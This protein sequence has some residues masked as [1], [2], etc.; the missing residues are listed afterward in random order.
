MVKRLSVGLV[1]VFVMSMLWLP[2]AAG[3]APS[4]DYTVKDTE[5]SSAPYHGAS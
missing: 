3:A 1:V 2:V 5:Y 4:G